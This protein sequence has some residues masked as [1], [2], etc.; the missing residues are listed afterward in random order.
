MA[1]LNGVISGQRYILIIGGKYVILGNTANIAVSQNTKD[2][3]CRE[4]DN[5]N[6]SL[7]K[8]R[9]WSMDFEGQL[10]WSYE[11]GNLTSRQFPFLAKTTDSIINEGFMNQE[12]LSI[13]LYAQPYPLAGL[14]YKQVTW[15]GRAYLTGTSIGAPNEANSTINLSFSGVGGLIQYIA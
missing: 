5:W 9:E 1:G 3:T 2:I 7:L 4:T 13:A 6:K 8:N 14:G 12:K 10:G 11:D 15:K